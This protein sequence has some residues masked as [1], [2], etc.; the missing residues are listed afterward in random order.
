MG[1]GANCSQTKVGVRQ[2][3]QTHGSSSDLGFRGMIYKDC[4]GFHV[5]AYPAVAC[6]EAQGFFLFKILEC[7][8]IPEF[9]EALHDLGFI[10]AYVLGCAVRVKFLGCID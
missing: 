2:F 4:H 1:A 9:P 10:M 7:T 6:T 8:V 3:K 5:R